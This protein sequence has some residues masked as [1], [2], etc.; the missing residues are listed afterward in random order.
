M[1]DL[2]IL[3]AEP[4]AY[5]EKAA[6]IL[7]S[8]GKVDLVQLNRAELLDC[9]DQYD[10]LIV[11]LGFQIDEE[12]FQ[13]ATRLKAVVTATTG[14]DHIDMTAAEKHGVKLL[15][16]RGEYEFLRSIP[17]TAELTWGLLIALVRNL[18]GAIN[19]VLADEWDR[20]GF[21]GYDLTGKKLGILGLGRIGEKIA[22]YGLAFGMH[23]A[24]YD[25]DPAKKMPGVDNLASMDALF[26]WSDVVT[27]HVPLNES[28]V[29]LV[30]ETQLSRMQDGY[31]VNTARG[32]VLDEGAL[33]KALQDDNL[34]GAAVDVICNERGLT[35]SASPLIEYAKEHDNLLITPHIGGASFDSMAATE[36]FMANK[37]KSYLETQHK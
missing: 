10:V 17:A 37:L 23:V 25:I 32:A 26:D 19:S 21:R 29:N 20:E 7:R 12:V 9:I 30:G 35:E 28:T 31:L 11:R 14:V 4:D 6:N 5:S 22:R 13:K 34:R 16:L 3:N 2:R 18:P 24:A 1:T 33:L 36:I 27:L 8:L 15:C